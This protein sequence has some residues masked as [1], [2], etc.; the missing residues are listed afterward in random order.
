MKKIAIKIVK[1]DGKETKTLT[2]LV[3]DLCM[4]FLDMADAEWLS[5]KNQYRN[6]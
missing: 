2:S 4:N 6:S 5:K 3:K 1:V